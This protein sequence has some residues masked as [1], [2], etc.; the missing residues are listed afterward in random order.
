MQLRLYR[1]WEYRA[2]ALFPLG[3]KVAIDTLQYR[4]HSD[5]PEWTD[6]P[7]VEETSGTTIFKV[8]D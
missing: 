7:I 3:E 6:V 8:E 2:T 1:T 5:F 4:H